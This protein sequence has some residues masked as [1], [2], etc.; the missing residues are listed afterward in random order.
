MNSIE[1]G[2]EVTGQRCWRSLGVV[3]VTALAIVAFYVV[4]RS[5]STETPDS[6]GDLDDPPRV[7]SPVVLMGASREEFREALVD[8]GAGAPVEDPEESITITGRILR[9]DGS[10]ARASLVEVAPW[11]VTP[12]WHGQSSST[13]VA[14]GPDGRFCLPID[15][16]CES[17][18]WIQAWSPQS[19]EATRGHYLLPPG[20]RDVT[21]IVFPAGC[22]EVYVAHPDSDRAANSWIEAKSVMW[23]SYPQTRKFSVDEQGRATICASVDSLS[24]VARSEGLVSSDIWSG[25][26]GSGERKRVTLHLGPPCS[27]AV[28]IHVSRSDGGRVPAGT[29]ILAGT[30]NSMLAPVV[31]DEAGVAQLKD[32]LPGHDLWVVARGLR[33]PSGEWWAN[34]T[35]QVYDASEWRRGDPLE[36]EIECGCNPEFAFRDPHGRPV[37]RL[38]ILI[39]G[40][41]DAAASGTWRGCTDEQG[42]W[43]PSTYG[44]MLPGRYRLRRVSG[45][46]LWDGPLERSCSTATIEVALPELRRVDV[47][48][49]DHRGELILDTGA[50]RIEWVDP[51]EFESRIVDGAPVAD[52]LPISLWCPRHDFE[53]AEIAFTTSS[54]RRIAGARLRSCEQSATG[55]YM[56]RVQHQALGAAEGWVVISSDVPLARARL[57]LSGPEEIQVRTDYRGRYAHPWLVPGRYEIRCRLRGI[58]E[59]AHLGEILVRPGTTTTTT[60]RYP[61]EDAGH[62]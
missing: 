49:V 33:L 4:L 57:T 13:T 48:V 17:V 40:L 53:N 39:E 41:D 31:V 62:R 59:S 22:L 61:P 18:H 14:A 55:E 20:S 1:A 51:I 26:I 34:R 37:A 58:D 38:G 8:L 56:L 52:S 32:V 47:T 21:L 5:S 16:S 2:R 7:I 12:T 36:F 43:R 25:A 54:G 6:Q 42:N 3:F 23:P 50:V 30:S 24:I 27:E 44:N 19:L 46:V 45:D 28:R 15:Q 9:A 11:A 29:T 10:P 60:L 35:K